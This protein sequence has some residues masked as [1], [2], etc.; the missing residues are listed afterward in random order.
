[1]I[2]YM[3]LAVLPAQTFS[4]LTDLLWATMGSWFT[5]WSFFQPSQALVSDQNKKTANDSLQVHLSQDR[6]TTSEQFHFLSTVYA[7]YKQDSAT[8]QQYIVYSS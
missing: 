6:W 1:M 8:F 4:E 7:S 2:S 3:C 5:K